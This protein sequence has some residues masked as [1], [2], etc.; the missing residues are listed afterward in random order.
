MTGMTGMGGFD[1]SGFKEMDLE[2]SAGEG[3]EKSDANGS[4]EKKSKEK[5]DLDQ[6]EMISSRKTEVK[7]EDLREGT[8]EPVFDSKARMQRKRPT[9]IE[10]DSPG[11]KKDLSDDSNESTKLVTQP[12]PSNKES[13][14]PAKEADLSAKRKENNR[15][16]FQKQSEAHRHHQHVQAEIVI[17][18]DDEE[19]LD[20]M[21]PPLLNSQGQIISNTN[22]SE[23]IGGESTQGEDSELLFN[24]MGPEI[25]DVGASPLKPTK[26]AYKRTA[27][28]PSD[29]D[30]SQQPLSKKFTRVTSITY[31]DVQKAE[32]A[33]N[34]QNELES[35]NKLRS[36]TLL[37]R[38]LTKF[39]GRR[40][41]TKKDKS[42]NNSQSS[43]TSSS[44]NSEDSMQQ[45]QLT[46][47]Y[48]RRANQRRRTTTKM[49][50]DSIIKLN[51]NMAKANGMDLNEVNEVTDVW[52][53][54]SDY[55]FE[56]DAHEENH[57]EQRRQSL[58]TKKNTKNKSFIGNT[59]FEYQLV[60]SCYK[61]EIDVV[62]EDIK[63][64]KVPPLEFEI[65]TEDQKLPENQLERVGHINLHEKIT[66]EH[67]E[68][69]LIKVDSKADQMVVAL[70]NGKIL[71][72][73]LK[74]IEIEEL[75]S[76]R[77]EVV[78]AVNFDPRHRLML[79]GFENGEVWIFQQQVKQMKAPSDDSTEDDEIK[80][81][82]CEKVT[83]Q[84][85]L[86]LYQLKG[87][88][89]II[90][91]IVVL[92]EFRAILL[93]TQDGRIFYAER[94]KYDKIKR[95][96]KSKFSF[97]LVEN[98]IDNGAVPHLMHKV[99]RGIDFVVQTL[100]N[101][102]RVYVH[103][104]TLDFKGLE[105]IK[106]LSAPGG[107][108]VCFESFPY[109]DTVQSGNGELK[110]LCIFWGYHICYY[111]MYYTKG[112]VV[113]PLGGVTELDTRMDYA[114]QF[115]DNLYVMI[116]ENA[117]ILQYS[118]KEHVTD[119]QGQKDR[120]YRVTAKFKP[121]NKRRSSLSFNK[122]LSDLQNLDTQ[123]LFIMDDSEDE[124]IFGNSEVVMEVS[125]KLNAN[126]ITKIKVNSVNKFQTDLIH[127]GNSQLFIMTKSGLMDYEMMCWVEYLHT[128]IHKEK[129]SF[130]LKVLN[131]IL[132]RKEIA[133]RGIPKD[134]A[135][136]EKKLK[137]IIITLMNAIWPAL[138]REDVED[139]EESMEY[140]TTICVMTLI[141]A[142]M[143]DFL[144]NGF[145]KKMVEYSLHG[146]FY[147]Y[148]F[149]LFENKILEK[150]TKEIVEELIEYYSDEEG[151]I[152]RMLICIFQYDEFKVYALNKALDMKLFNLAFYLS[153]N[154]KPED[155]VL[156][157]DKLMTNFRSKPEDE[158]NPFYHKHI[159]F[160]MMFY[161]QK[162]II[163]ETDQEEMEVIG[164]E[165]PAW[166]VMN[167]LI[168]L[169]NTGD[170]IKEAAIPFLKIFLYLIEA[171]LSDE[172]GKINQ[173]LPSVPLRIGQKPKICSTQTSRYL[174]FFIDEVFDSLVGGELEYAVYWF[175]MALHLHSVDAEVTNLGLN[176]EYQEKTLVYMTENLDKLVNTPGVPLNQD[177]LIIK[178]FRLFHSNMNLY[179]EKPALVDKLVKLQ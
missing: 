63:E 28:K 88:N 86:K 130:T 2:D 175:L 67:G 16:M 91:D 10:I 113:L 27:T 166:R 15:S 39:G 115:D 84:R 19:L 178:I 144:L 1:L 174:A 94:L 41:V 12:S 38:G 52:H 159:L 172:I 30:I 100:G 11:G 68:I 23:L 69:A 74:T 99:F 106:V 3:K 54:D 149:L 127:H 102:A 17:D 9:N 152:K 142:G 80:Q 18:S 29:N 150:M 116:D 51:S 122:R 32:A 111:S 70:K 167:W 20:S 96:E 22:N 139:R 151:Y 95:I 103:R 117:Q 131:K 45:E 121:I 168:D 137:P 59:R 79:I 73:D 57:E 8:K 156:P 5:E 21:P 43:Q 133:L 81:A 7:A 135:E 104:Y 112:K 110:V 162:V 71:L 155:S 83:Y 26:R 48:R 37:G 92:E 148:I 123:D 72:V 97:K 177:D 61:G 119:V 36:R 42:R 78:T 105:K 47:I 58:K 87:L 126:E 147:S 46:N 134:T 171:G 44:S 128:T 85:C 179:L 65:I 89:I 56:S 165:H 161:V 4:A 136:V 49:L 90:K 160:E 125:F 157:L 140:F 60:A 170:L 55:S 101:T 50:S 24:S 33:K 120:K 25:N 14:S 82:S 169:K 153:E 75:P 64:S 35:P 34:G 66:N 62:L 109:F 108:P 53:S 163:I 114:A 6:S 138:T 118:L 107:K 146:F 141:K 154:A 40:K 145:K 158:K 143:E 164:E 176:E 13:E 31:Q 98:G 124:D 93:N 77:K 173:E 129:F 132:E 76:M